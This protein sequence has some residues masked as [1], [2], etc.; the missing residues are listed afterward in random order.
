MVF[1]SVVAVRNTVDT[2]H[3]QVTQKRR[4]SSR[5]VRYQVRSHQPLSRCLSRLYF[6]L[7]HA[8]SL[9]FVSSRLPNDQVCLSCIEVGV[10]NAPFFSLAQRLRN[11]LN[12]ASGSGSMKRDGTRL[13]GLD[14]PIL[15][16]IKYNSDLSCL[17]A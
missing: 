12:R 2:L 5:N 11:G 16:M 15:S 7:P 14:L 17:T 1:L 10:P 13:D 4:R 8:Q 9:S 6:C 3:K